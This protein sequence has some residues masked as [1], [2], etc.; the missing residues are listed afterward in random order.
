MSLYHYVRVGALG[1]LGRFQ[2]IDARRYPRDSRVVLRTVRGLEIGHVL[3]PPDRDDQDQGQPDGSIL[4]GMTVEDELLADR[5]EK[6]KHRAFEACTQ[7][8]ADLNEEATL[9][10]VEH[11]F[12]GR[13]LIFYFL[14][15]ITPAIERITGELADTYESK[16]KFRNFTDALTNGCGPNCG[17]ENAEGGCKSCVS[18]AVSAACGA[19]K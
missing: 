17:T 8:L 13:S 6:N 11:L 3:A 18:C 14:G 12:D 15:A 7:R 10:D 9:I 16:V 1:Q 2:A 4:R 5:L 19:A